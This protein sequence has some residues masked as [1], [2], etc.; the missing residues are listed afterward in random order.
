MS[1][2]KRFLDKCTSTDVERSP[3]PHQIIE[4]TL[5]ENVFLKLKNNEKQRC[6]IS[7]TAITEASLPLTVLA[8]VLSKNLVR[9]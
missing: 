5:S 4:N 2:G 9:L 3:W 7:I 1:E 8:T 6:Q